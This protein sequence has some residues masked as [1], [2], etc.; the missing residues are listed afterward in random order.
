MLPGKVLF[1]S[2]GFEKPST[3]YRAR[4]YEFLLSKNGW[5]V[6]YVTASGNILTKINVL[7]QVYFANVVVVLRKN[8]GAFNFLLLNS[9][10]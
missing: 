6:D 10:L 9:L 8:F 7:K 1:V 5:T 4:Q 3:R 2:K